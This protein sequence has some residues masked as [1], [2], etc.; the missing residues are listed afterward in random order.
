MPVRNS[1]RKKSDQS[2]R[3]SPRNSPRHRPLHSPRRSPGQR[4][5]LHPYGAP[6][7]RHTGGVV[8]AG[9]PEADARNI[10]DWFHAILQNL[11]PPQPHRRNDHN[12]RLRGRAALLRALGIPAHEEP[13]VDDVRRLLRRRM[14]NVY[15]DRLH[16]RFNPALDDVSIIY[17]AYIVTL[18]YNATLDELR[19]SQ[20]LDID[21]PVYALMGMA[22]EQIQK[23]KVDWFRAYLD[24]E[25][26]DQRLVPS[27]R[28]AIADY[29]RDEPHRRAREEDERRRRAREEDERLDAEAVL[30]L[31]QLR[32]RLQRDEAEQQ[33]RQEDAAGVVAWR[34]HWDQVERNTPIPTEEVI[35]RLYPAIGDGRR[36]CVVCWEKRRSVVYTGC[37]HFLVCED[38]YMDLRSN[39]N[40]RCP[41]CNAVSDG[42]HLMEYRTL[43]P[44]RNAI[45]YGG[46]ARSPSGRHKMMI[47]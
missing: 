42:M 38:C 11:Q 12:P 26:A 33:R 40:N 41:A 13:T 29:D 25:H 22:P 18:V 27:I 28:M 3:Q 14:T 35:V 1:N 7:K 24:R 16:G 34:A 43:Y 9:V 23:A 21:F 5:P 17:Y 45:M 32:L 47:A 46:R 39:G 6:N 19:D 44:D 31:E 30:L 8:P 15:P 37:A 36:E 4:A 20:S 2:P 10:H